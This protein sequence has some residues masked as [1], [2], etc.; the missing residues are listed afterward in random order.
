M[1]LPLCLRL[2]R[3]PA[4]QSLASYAHTGA[5]GFAVPSRSL[6]QL[7][8]VGSNHGDAFTLL[9]LGDVAYQYTLRRGAARAESPRFSRSA[10]LA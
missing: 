6:A 3:L 5:P 7:V 2:T 9:C 10:R 8:E 1:M 4:P